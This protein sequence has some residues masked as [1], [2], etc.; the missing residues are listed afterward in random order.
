[1]GY[2]ITHRI[3]GQ[4]VATAG[5]TQPI[6]NPATGAEVGTLHL[7]DADTVDQAVRSAARASDTFAHSR[8]A[9]A[10]EREWAKV[11]LARRTQILFRMR[12]LVIEATDEI[13][14]PIDRQ[15]T[16]L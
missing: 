14:V 15:S 12:Q 11:S 13:A 10:A 4:D 7:G 1:M 2:E 9:R 3:G 6:M 5:S 8:W 16:R